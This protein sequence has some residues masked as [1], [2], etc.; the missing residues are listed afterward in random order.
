[1]CVCECALFSFSFSLILDESVVW[2]IY[3]LFHT[4]SLHWVMSL[5]HSLSLCFFPHRLCSSLHHLPPSVCGRSS[6]LHCFTPLFTL[7]F[8]PPSHLP[9]IFSC[10]LL[11][12]FIPS[13]LLLFFCKGK[14]SQ[15]YLYSQFGL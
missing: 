11:T 3:L 5:T 15:F 12:A 10:C 14:A 2:N 13:I 7:H 1:M 4:A 6:S 8:L 9:F